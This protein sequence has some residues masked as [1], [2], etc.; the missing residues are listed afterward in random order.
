MRAPSR[1]ACLLSVAADATDSA[2][3]AGPLVASVAVYGVVL[4]VA[5]EAAG[6]DGGNTAGSSPARTRC[7]RRAAAV[8]NTPAAYRR[9]EAV[10]R[11]PSQ[12]CRY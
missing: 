4:V 8:R 3:V 7:R 12:A 1:E 11:R 6:K 5:A 10:A 9:P 2:L